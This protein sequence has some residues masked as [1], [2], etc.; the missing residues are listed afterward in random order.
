[1]ETT[2]YRSFEAFTDVV[3]RVVD[4]RARVSSI[5]RFGRIGR[6]RFVLE[7]RVPAGVDNRITW[8]NW[9]DERCSRHSVSLPATGLTEWRRR[10]HRELQPGKSLIVRYG[11]PAK[12]LIPMLSA[13]ITPPPK[14]DH[15]SCWTSMAF[16]LP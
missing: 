1:M 6:F 15:S 4:A 7:I 13:R 14:P 8:S 16:G 5:V 2:A 11:E 10:S 3:M 9:I 12:R